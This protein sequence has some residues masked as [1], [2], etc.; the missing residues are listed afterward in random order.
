LDPA[1]ATFEARVSLNILTE[2]FAAFEAELLVSITMPLR[3][4]AQHILPAFAAFLHGTTDTY[5]GQTGD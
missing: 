5:G 3:T 4:V 1:Q 2:A